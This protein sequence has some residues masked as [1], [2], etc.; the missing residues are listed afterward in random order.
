MHS[1]WEYV[2]TSLQHYASEADYEPAPPR[3]NVKLL[4]AK[5]ALEARRDGVPLHVLDIGVGT[6]KN[7][8]LAFFE[9]FGI[10]FDCTSLS[11]AHDMAPDIARIAKFTQ[12]K[13]LYL[14]FPGASY[15]FVLSHYGVYEQL[16]PAVENAMFLLKPGGS[17]L[18]SGG[19]DTKAFGKCLSCNTPVYAVKAFDPPVK[20]KKNHWFIWLQKTG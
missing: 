17:A 18:F 15:D 16:C 20:E 10:S 14:H 19:L 9:M 13:D 2:N 7:I 1:A 12:A 11:R 5:A 6:G 4:L 3:P 8:D